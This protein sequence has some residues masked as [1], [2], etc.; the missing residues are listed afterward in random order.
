MLASHIASFTACARLLP[1]DA[2]NQEAA[3]KRASR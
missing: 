1:D 3:M 2:E